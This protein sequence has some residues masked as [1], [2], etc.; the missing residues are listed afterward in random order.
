MND[1]QLA[2]LRKTY[3][4]RTLAETDVLPDAV[5]QFRQWLD[6][7]LAA[8]LDEPTALTLSTVNAAGQ[9]SS[10]VVLLKGLPDDAGFLFY[11]NYDSRKGQELAEQPLAALN[12][13][14]PG[15]ERQVRVEGRVEKAPPAMST[16]YF[17]SRPRG[18]QL[19]AW[20]SPQS[21]VIGSREELEA[22]EQE[23]EEQFKGQ[24]PLPR[25]ENW[26]GYILRP[27]R[28]EFWQG[29]PSRLHDRIVYE[30]AGQGWQ[31]SR[32]AP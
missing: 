29:R 11:T 28:V 20:A 30:R 8:K 9:P 1:T 24:D 12:F 17:Q 23:L 7:A 16:E 21:Q 2:D 25:P 4:Q 10:R 32:L 5:Q 27:H 31:R 15:L 13:F 22:R 3:S 14:W 18:S 19:G 26:G 6:E